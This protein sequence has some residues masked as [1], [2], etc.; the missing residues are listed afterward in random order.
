[1]SQERVLKTLL[2]FGLTEMDAKVYIFL[3]KKGLQK[4]IDI[5]K[6]MKMNKEQL[7]RSL[8]KL[9]SKGIVTATL[10]HPARFSAL[11]FEKALDLF[12]KAKM[13]E[14]QE[15][16]QN[17]DEILSFFQSIAVKET[18]ASARFTVIEGRNVIYSKIQQMIQETKSKLSA[19]STVP[20]LMRADQFGLFDVGSEQ[21]LKSEIQFRFL[22]EVSE[23]NIDA[24]KSLLKEMTNAKISF[25]GRTPDLGLRL[26][27]RMV[28]RDE[29]EAVFFI[30]AKTEVSMTEQDNACLWT[31]CKALVHAFTAMFEDL[32]RNS[33]DIRKK[34]VEIETGAPTP[35]TYIISDAQ[36]AQKRYDEVVNSAEKEI[37]VMT[38][39]KGLIRTWRNMPLLKEWVKKGVSVKI[40]API[41]SENLEAAQQLLQ[42]SAVKHVPTSY[43]GTAIIDGKHLFQFKTPPPEQEKLDATQYFENTFYSNDL[44]YVEKTRTMLNDIWKNASTPSATTIETALSPPAP[45]LPI[46]K[47]IDKPKIFGKLLTRMHSDLSVTAIIHPPSHL[48]MPDVIIVVNR[49]EKQSTFGPSVNM[50]VY[51]RFE[52]PPAHAPIPVR[53]AAVPVAMVDTNPHPSLMLMLKGMTAGTPAAQNVIIVKPD[54]L[55]LYKRGNTIFAGWTMPIPLPPTPHSLPPSCLIAEGYGNPSHSSATYDLPSGYKTT[56]NMTGRDAFLTYISPSWNYSGPGTEGMVSTDLVYEV[57]AP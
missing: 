40:M 17:K 32:W 35:K 9:Q 33:T 13:E 10:E 51:L 30:T 15:I 23:Q 52:T 11:P 57:Y 19:I 50:L 31:N 55:E 18:D 37:L 21:P 27:P 1:M 4:A 45:T 41:M 46:P 24:M 49:S 6:S 7:Y 12:V 26:F 39:S 2:G 25:E 43:L 34:T 47:V 5:A 36:T 48:N 28:I 29:E 56:V 22:T 54:Q 44:E 42:F 14:A 38:S 8:K 53:Y 3:A 16:K 20:S